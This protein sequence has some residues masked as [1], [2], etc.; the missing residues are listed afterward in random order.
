MSEVVTNDRNKKTVIDF[1]VDDY[2]HK[3][4]KQHAHIFYNQM[5]E[6]PETKEHHH[7]LGKPNICDFWF[8]M[9]PTPTWYSICIMQK[10]EENKNSK[11][12]ITTR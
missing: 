4:L 1:K 3:I 12:I 9:L 10:Q 2:E 6:D 7:L 5:I 11:L 8:E